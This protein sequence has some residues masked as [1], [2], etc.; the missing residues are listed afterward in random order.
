MRRRV[1]LLQAAL[2]TDKDGTLSAV[3]IAAAPAALKTLDRNGDSIITPDEL[4]A[5]PTPVVVPTEQL[6]ARLMEFDRNEDG[7]LALKELP[8]RIRKTFVDAD[9][10]KD[11]ILTPAELGPFLVKQEETR[12]KEDDDR[13]KKDDERQEAER[14]A[15]KAPAV[16]GPV[17]PLM[18]A[19]DTDKDGA[20]SAAEIA[21][22]AT[23]L[24]TLDKD[25]DGV[26]SAEEMT[27][28][29]PAVSPGVPPALH[30]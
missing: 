4:R 29:R 8:E 1:S 15:G 7:K 23:A 9:T 27:P 2:D 28:P 26:I 25:G 14:R 16:T 19:L 30:S 24:K 6:I 21:A 20:I 22:A 13:R 3:E 12:A 5:I 18:A 11:G 17:A 10:D